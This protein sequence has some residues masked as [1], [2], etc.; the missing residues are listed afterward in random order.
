MYRAKELGR[1]R[2]EVFNSSMHAHAL[3]LL[4][5]E[6]DLRRAIDPIRHQVRDEDQEQEPTA[7]ETSGKSPKSHKSFLPPLLR[8]SQFIIHY[9][10]IVSIA[11]SQITGFEALV[12]WQ[13]P[14]RGLVPPSEFITIAE[15]TGLIISLGLWVLR[16]ACHQIREWQQLFQSNPP[17]SVSVN[18]SVKQFSQPD[19]IEYIDQVAR[20]KSPRR[21]QFKIRNYRKR[22]H[23][24]FRISNSNAGRTQG[25]Q[26]TFVHRRLRHRRFITLLPAPLPHQY[27]KNRPLFC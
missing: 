14:E 18:L 10:P 25:P 23:G 27:L 13:H 15:E 19:L 3:R 2:H 26:H 22:T 1:A 24:K 21:Q 5:L 7:S 12:R 6:N 8:T 9:Q 20:R 17:L 16:T 4:Q 11:N